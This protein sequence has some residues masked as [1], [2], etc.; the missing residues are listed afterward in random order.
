MGALS[1]YYQWQETDSGPVAHMRHS[2]EN[3]LQDAQAD[4][5]LVSAVYHVHELLR[6]YNK[7]TR[8]VE[9]LRIILFASEEA[10]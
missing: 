9:K 2:P 1:Q 8:L 6:L 7:D 4:M 10:S 3:N 5:A